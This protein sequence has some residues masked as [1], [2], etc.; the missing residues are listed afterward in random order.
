MPIFHFNSF[1]YSGA[2]NSWKI[3]W[4]TFP[5]FIYAHKLP[6]IIEKNYYLKKKVSLLAL[7]E[8]RTGF[9]LIILIFAVWFFFQ[10]GTNLGDSPNIITE[11][12]SKKTPQKSTRTDYVTP[13]FTILQEPEN[14]YPEFL[15][16]EVELPNQVR[17]IKDHSFSTYVKF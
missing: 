12:S 7:T 6:Q 11:V 9:S 4:R 17:T 16:L 2:R 14:G 3:L 8:L 15:V 13:V 10:L 1:Q 5:A